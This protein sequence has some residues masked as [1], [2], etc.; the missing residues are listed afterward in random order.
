MADKPRVVYMIKQFP[1]ISETYVKS[2]IEAVS[3]EWDVLAIGLAKPDLAYRNPA[4]HQ[5][6]QDWDEVV[7]GG[8]AAHQRRP[9]PRGVN[10]PLRPTIARKGWRTGRQ[11]S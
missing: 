7:A 5:I 9:V 3:D 8:G 6:I 10:L 11:A 2:E 1:Q 4:R